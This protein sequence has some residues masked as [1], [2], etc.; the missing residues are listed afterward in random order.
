MTI[1]IPGKQA[2]GK[3]PFWMKR[4]A[5]KSARIGRKS[6]GGKS[7][8]LQFLAFAQ[9]SKTDAIPSTKKASTLTWE[10]PA[11]DLPKGWIREIYKREKGA[12]KGHK[13]NYWISPKKDMKF[14]SLVQAKKFLTALKV[15]KGDKEKANK[16]RKKNH[17]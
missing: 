15:T 2:G 14:R 6:V 11:I 7:P 4:N 13:D 17:L 1:T 8:N 3:P 5:R 9:A 10:G 16:L 12:S